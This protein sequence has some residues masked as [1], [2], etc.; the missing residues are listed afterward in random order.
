[1]E[2]GSDRLIFIVSNAG[3]PGD[4]GGTPARIFGLNSFKGEKR[5]LKMTSPYP[6]PSLWCKQFLCPVGGFVGGLKGDE[7]GFLHG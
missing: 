6:R 7:R 5:T 3:S 1:M 2:S 4:T